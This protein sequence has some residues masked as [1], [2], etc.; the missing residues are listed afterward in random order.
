MERLFSSC[1]RLYDLLESRRVESVRS[2]RELLQEVSMDVSTEELLSAETGCTYTNLYAML[3]NE[4]A[5]VWLTPHAAVMPYG[6]REIHPW[7]QMDG[8]CRSLLKADGKEL[9]VLALSPEHLSEICDILLRILAASVVHSVLL[10][11]WNSLQGLLINPP[12]LAYLMERCQS[13]KALAL[14]DQEMHSDHCRVLGEYS[15]P[16][17]EI[18]LTRCGFT[19]AGTTALT[20]VL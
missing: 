2:R 10:D 5:V 19:S 13:L 6:G 16:G 8:S 17:L 7:M 20:E 14:F 15:R 4:N 18:E 1:T 11:K 9:C 12:T 3:G